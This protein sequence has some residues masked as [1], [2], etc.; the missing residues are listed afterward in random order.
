[1]LSLLFT[2][3]LRMFIKALIRF[4]V[5][6]VLNLSCL[7]VGYAT[8]TDDQS[9]TPVTTIVIAVGD[10]LAEDHEDFYYRQLLDLVLKK[11]I[12]TY[13]PYEIKLTLPMPIDYR[14]MREIEKNRVDVTWSSY[15]SSIES[16]VSVVK[17][18]LLKGISNYRV[19]LIR[20]DD[21]ERFNAVSSLDNLR[22]LKCGIGAHWPDRKIM[23][24]NNLP[25][26]VHIKYENL[27]KMLLLKRFDYYSRGVYQI[28]PEAEKYRNMGLV[29]E[30]RLMLHYD[31]P[32]YFHVN[33]NNV[34]LARR[35]ED[36]LKIV[37]EDGSF[38]ELFNRF[39]RFIWAREQIDSANRLVIN[40]KK[41]E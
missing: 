33:K 21:Q 28:L 12:P 35:L 9:Y 27:F 2:S 8:V 5:V 40:L 32:V 38:D 16:L 30:Q 26:I 3:S 23:E 11:T 13:G 34:L 25:T 10:N 18:D 7:T 6:S 17:I 37:M 4:F 24:E 22:K 19:F 15:Q 1:M 20:Q 14:L 31:N 36:G 39:P 29:I 41:F